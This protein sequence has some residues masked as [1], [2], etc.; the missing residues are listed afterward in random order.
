[1]HS[2]DIGEHVAKNFDLFK[3]HVISRFSMRILSK[4]TSSADSLSVSIV[5]AEDA[6]SVKEATS[7]VRYAPAKQIEQFMATSETFPLFLF[8]EG[9]V[10]FF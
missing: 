7:S 2:H 9:L 6:V 4:L 5:A 10:G 3:V 1:M 8:W